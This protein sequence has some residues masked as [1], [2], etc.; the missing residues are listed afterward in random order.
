MKPAALLLALRTGEGDPVTSGGLSV[1]GTGPPEAYHLSCSPI[2]TLA[3]ARPVSST[4]GLRIQRTP[5]CCAGLPCARLSRGFRR[6]RNRRSKGRHHTS[7]PEVAVQGHQRPDCSEERQHGKTG[8][9]LQRLPWII[10]STA[11]GSQY[12]KEKLA[13]LGT[14]SSV[15]HRI[16]PGLAVALARPAGR[17]A[18]GFR[19]RFEL[20]KAAG[21]V[22]RQL[23][24]GR[25]T[26]VRQA[27]GVISRRVYWN[28]SWMGK[29]PS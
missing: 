10:C 5:T 29:W 26:I 8:A 6:T 3:N 21:K 27:A 25:A 22:V 20:A 7:G 14:D 4:I 17:L 1:D 19:A 11:L 24:A 2:S 28:E 23:T 15:S 13:E 12:G 16:Q 18:G 9:R